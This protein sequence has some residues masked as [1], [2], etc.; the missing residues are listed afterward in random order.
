MI[1]IMGFERDMANLDNLLVT[2]SYDINGVVQPDF[3]IDVNMQTVARSTLNE[4]KN[5]I[6]AKVAEQRGT[7]LYEEVKTKLQPYVGVNLEPDSPP[8]EPEP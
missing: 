4:A 3:V 8:P 6:L 5:Y 1:K 2:L 7:T